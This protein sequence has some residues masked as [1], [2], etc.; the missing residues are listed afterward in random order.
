MSDDDDNHLIAE[1]R[2]KLARL[3][4]RGIAF[5]N[6]FRRNALAADLAR[7]Y[8]GKSPEALAAEAVRVSVAGRLRRKNVMGKG[9]FAKIE[10]G[11]GGIQVR[12]ERDTLHEVYEDFKTWD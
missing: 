7:A 2:A 1:R 3:R 11:S 10:D 4:E 5:P 12:L 8:G 6:Q 9:S